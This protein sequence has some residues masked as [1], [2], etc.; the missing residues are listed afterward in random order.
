M[1]SR[2]DGPV[3]NTKGQ[4]QKEEKKGT[5]RGR[6]ISKPFSQEDKRAET[7]KTRRG[8]RDERRGE[9]NSSAISFAEEMKR[10]L[11]QD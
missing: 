11:L 10:Q 7:P 4:K 8:E 9:R 3:E 5:N 6:A 1:G 2:C